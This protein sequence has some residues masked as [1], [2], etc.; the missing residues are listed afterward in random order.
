MRFRF[1]LAV[2]VLSTG[3]AAA[4]N[5]SC[6]QQQARTE[7]KRLTDD[8]AILSTDEFMP[9]ITVVVA[10]RAWKRL[11][12]DGKKALAQ[13]VRCA[14]AGS[15]TGMQWTILIRS[16]SADLLAVFADDALTIK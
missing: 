12:I 14:L 11:D 7:L 15:D 2:L 9:S 8:A 5:Y 6:D 3:V 16:R 10:D 1:G 4:Q 13:T